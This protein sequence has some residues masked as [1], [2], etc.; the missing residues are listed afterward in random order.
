MAAN[1][2]VVVW[3]EGKNKKEMTGVVAES[4]IQGDIVRWPPVS[5]VTK[6]MQNRKPPQKDWLKFSLVKIKRTSGMLT[7]FFK[8][9]F[10]SSILWAI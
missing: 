2:C 5:N 9:Q 4:W 3:T 7:L 6:Y 1:Y 8:M 10:S